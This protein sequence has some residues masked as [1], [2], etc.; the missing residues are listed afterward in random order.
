MRLI[1]MTEIDNEILVID[2][3][4]GVLPPVGATVQLY[5]PEPNTPEDHPPVMIR[6]KV[7]DVEVHYHHNPARTYA[8]VKVELT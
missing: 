4:Q 1:F 2:E 3:Y 7:E 6:G 5:D 8:S